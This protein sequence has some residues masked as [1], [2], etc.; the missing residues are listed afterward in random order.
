L[1]MRALARDVTG[2]KTGHPGFHS[3]L[4]QGLVMKNKMLLGTVL[5]GMLSMGQAFAG[6]TSL[7]NAT[8]TATYNGLASGMLGLDHSFADELGSNITQLDPTDSSIEF[9][10]SDYT[11]G[12]DFS[13]SGLL[14][15]YGNLDLP[16]G[17][18]NL[19]FDFGSTLSES[20]SGFSIVDA[21]TVS[22]TPLLSVLNAHSISVNINVDAS[23][24]WAE[25]N[26]VT[27]QLAFTAP[28]PEPLAPAMLLAGLGVLGLSR[29]FSKK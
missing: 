29:R 14:T 19:T 18:Y 28:V 1:L 25:L 22:A 8:I 13:K 6:A 5:V 24:T 4:G 16:V 26:T 20:I 27:T 12:F 3:L 23:H 2:F 15:I 11:M 9:L 21:S 17:A 7:Q 10:T